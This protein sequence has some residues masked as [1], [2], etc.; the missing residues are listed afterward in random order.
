M[1]GQQ[2][3]KEDKIDIKTATATVD[4]ESERENPAFIQLDEM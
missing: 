3:N 4:R 1:K 2:K